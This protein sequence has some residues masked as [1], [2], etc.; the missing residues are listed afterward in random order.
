MPDIRHAIRIAASPHTLRTLVTEAPG[1]SQWWAE[2]AEKGP[3]GSVSLGFFNRTT[4]YNLHLLENKTRNVV[5]FCESGK[6]WQGTELA[7]SFRPEGAETV[8][9][10]AHRNWREITPYFISCNTTWG[11]LMF[12]LKSAAEGRQCGP[13]FR[14]GALDY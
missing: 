10:F 13:L 9:D 8:L 2:D 7:F 14:R 5:W 3:D 4:I 11:G 1:L 12:R 6:E